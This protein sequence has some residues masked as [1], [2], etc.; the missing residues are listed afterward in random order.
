[1]SVAPF[2]SCFVTIF[3]LPM[4]QCCGYNGYRLGV[5][6]QYG[7][8]GGEGIESLSLGWSQAVIYAFHV[9]VNVDYKKFD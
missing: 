9:F 2:L 6:K 4:A 3:E 5:G 7:Q 8:R 1:M